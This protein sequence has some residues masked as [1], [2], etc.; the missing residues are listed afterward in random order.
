MLSF[1]TLIDAPADDLSSPTQSSLSPTSVPTSSSDPTSTVDLFPAHLISQSVASSL[2][3]GYT[4]R[5]LR[6]SDGL[7]YHRFLSLLNPSLHSA[8]SSHSTSQSNLDIKSDSALV[9]GGA[10][11]SGTENISSHDQASIAEFTAQFDASIACPE[12]YYTLVILDK[13]ASVVGTGSIF[14]AR[15]FTSIRNR[16][17][18]YSSSLNGA[19]TP[20]DAG[21]GAKPRGNKVGHIEDIAVLH[22]QRGN[23]LGL[24][25]VQALE[26]IARGVNCYKASHYL[27]RWRVLLREVHPQVQLSPMLRY[28]QVQ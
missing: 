16:A 1:S 11:A 24:R 6:R 17:V 15:T 12:T 26:Y 5:P 18:A 13:E 22:S 21:G 8:P 19:L 7:I 27:L 4:I 20:G 14:V 25:I 28:F 23:R 9:N 10:D 2:P 3:P